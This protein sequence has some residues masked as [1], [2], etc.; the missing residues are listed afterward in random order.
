MT[1][2]EYSELKFICDQSYRTGYVHIHVTYVLQSIEN[3]A[4]YEELIKY[5]QSRETT[6]KNEK[7]D[8]ANKNLEDGQE[9]AEEAKSEDGLPTYDWSSASA[10][11]PSRLLGYS[12]YG[13][14]TDKLTATSGGDIDNSGDRKNIIQNV[15]ESI[16][17]A[18][19]FL[20]GVDR[21]LS[22]GIENLYIA[23][24]A[25]QMFTYYTVD[26]KVNAS[27]E[28]E[29]LS[30]ENLT[31]LSGYEFSSSNHKAYKAETEYILWGKSSS[32]K[33]VQATVAVIYGIR[34]LFNVFYALTDP[35]INTSATIVAA[36]W[37]T[38]APYL[39]PIIKIVYKLGLALC[40]TTDDIKDI[41]AGYGVAL[42]KG[43]GTWVTPTIDLSF[44]NADNTR[45]VLTLDYS[46][47]LR[48]FLNTAMMASGYQP[49][50]ARIGDC[51]Q[52]NTDSDITKMSTMLSVEATVTNRT[53]FMRKIA[54]WSGAG[55]Q[56]G[57][58]YSIDYKSVLG[59]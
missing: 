41:K 15:K 36:P 52:V 4:F 53:T 22:D 39:E 11:L 48:L 27:H 55:W 6:E 2:D 50:L 29:T 12:S 8:Q 24:Y 21:I 47:Y 37:A 31:S 1:Y 32:K 13:A 46:E 57:D 26:K 5:C 38:V 9:G 14:S 10:T 42:T 20:D 58:S 45:G 16:K 28:I 18:N 23:E 54:D 3:D 40:E 7:K 30:G 33:N 34:L 17:Q 19:S 35:S 59:Y 49:A 25:M 51:I 44:W 43:E 56:Y